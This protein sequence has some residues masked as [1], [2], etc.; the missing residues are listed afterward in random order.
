M[1]PG[2]AP[3]KLFSTLRGINTL[4]LDPGEYATMK[5]INEV[6]GKVKKGEKANIVVFWKWIEVKDEDT[7]EDEKIPLLRYYRVFEINTQCEGLKSR[8]QGTEFDHDPITEAEKIVQ[9]FAGS[10]PIRFATDRAFYRPS[11][12]FISV[13]PLKD[14]PVPAE[15]Y[16][17]LFHEMV[18]S[19]GHSKRLN[20]P[21]VAHF[22]EF[23]SE[24]YSKEELIAEMGAAMLCGMAGIDN[25]TMGRRLALP[26]KS[27]Q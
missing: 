22:D 7:G 26:A 11:A 1:F 19:T 24:Q 12:D 16:S 2:R 27:N 17:T 13:P 3:K 5:Q 14:Y 20:R 4:I 6:G 8:R 18:H 23:G 15:Y 21:G 10:P 9:G 25:S